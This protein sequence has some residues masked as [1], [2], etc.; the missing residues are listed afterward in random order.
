MPTHLKCA[1]SLRLVCTMETAQVTSMTRASPTTW[2]ALKRGGP[3][4]P[5]SS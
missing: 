5:M 4:C 1:S 2:T 3:M